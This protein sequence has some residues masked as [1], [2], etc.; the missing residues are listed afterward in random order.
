MSSVMYPAQK[1]KVDDL[2]FPRTPNRLPGSCGLRVQQSEVYETMTSTCGPY[3]LGSSATAGIGACHCRSVVVLLYKTSKQTIQISLK[4][5]LVKK[6]TFDFLLFAEGC[7]AILH[8]F[9]WRT[10]FSTAPEYFKSNS[11]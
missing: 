1:E 4:P 5:I 8:E 9:M 3:D 11:P 6:V 2:G 7:S 10:N